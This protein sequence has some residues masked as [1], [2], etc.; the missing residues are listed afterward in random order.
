[1]GVLTP[2]VPPL[3][4]SSGGS[5]PVLFCSTP[6]SN[7]VQGSDV[8]LVASKELRDGTP[9]S[10]GHRLQSVTGPQ[11]GHGQPGSSR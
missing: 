3:V 4:S 10:S 11:L 8:S 7:D 5:D 6:D 9:G 1:M 2:I